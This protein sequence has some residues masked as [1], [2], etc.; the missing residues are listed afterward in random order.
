MPN[1]FSKKV[2]TTPNSGLSSDR[3][4][5]LNLEQAEPN[6][7]YPGEK[8][9]GI[10]LS[11]DYY[12]LAIKNN[13]TFSD[14]FWINDTNILSV[15]GISIFKDNTLVGTANSI[16]TINFKG[17]II[18]ASAS[19]NISTITGTFN[20]SGSTFG[21]VVF[22]DNND[23]TTSSK[24]SFNPSV[25]ILTV[26]DGLFV[27]DLFFVTFN[28]V[29]IGSEYPSEKLYINGNSLI[30]NDTESEYLISEN[31]NIN[32]TKI[33]YLKDSNNST[34]SA[35]QIL[36]STR[37]GVFWTNVI[38]GIDGTWGGLTRSRTHN[39]TYTNNTGSLLYV[40]ATPEITRTGRNQLTPTQIAGSYSIAEVDG[41]E[42]DRIRDN[43]TANANSLFLNVSFFVPNGSS[44]IVKVYNHTGSQWISTVTT[45]S[46]SEFKF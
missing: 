46:W 2:K 37:F 26:S 44:Y 1:Y 24:L 23:F 45:S 43:G 12:S 8:T 36:S 41:I 38:V 42:V 5:F 39:V 6:L 20:V 19:G 33:T 21:E 30:T 10:P 27:Q 32:T 13:S 35:N 17:N 25:G 40:S 28:G 11:E 7:G 9:G 29:G 16:N 4:L 18:N 31:G 22:S 34:G 14:K 3:Y 15:S